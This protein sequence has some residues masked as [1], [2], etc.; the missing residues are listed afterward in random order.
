MFNWVLNMHLPPTWK[1]N[2]INKF[3]D[4]TTL[5][6]VMREISKFLFI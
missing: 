1:T 2:P 3:L 5:I 6:N 4:L